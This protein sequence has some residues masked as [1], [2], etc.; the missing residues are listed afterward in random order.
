MIT[1]KNKG[2]MYLSKIAKETDTTY[3]YV[4]N[5]M[6]TLAARRWVII[7]EKGKYRVA[8]LTE[9]GIELAKIISEIYDKE[10]G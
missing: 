8:R 7:E 10:K 1:L 2:P 4:T 6:R 5:L 9:D 3:V